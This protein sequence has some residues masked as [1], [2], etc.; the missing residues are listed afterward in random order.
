MPDIDIN[1]FESQAEYYGHTSGETKPVEE[2][3][4]VS[5]TP[6]YNNLFETFSK[7]MG[8]D[9]QAMTRLNRRKTDRN[10]IHS[11]FYNLNLAVQCMTTPE[12]IT[13]LQKITEEAVNSSWINLPMNKSY[14]NQLAKEKLGEQK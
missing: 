10:T 5:V 1:T 3:H 14:R 11:F 2:T 12:Q 13:K 9:V 4:S 7:A 6:D 8:N